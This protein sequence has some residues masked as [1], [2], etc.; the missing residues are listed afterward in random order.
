LNNA[1]FAD[2][3]SLTSVEFP[4]ATVISSYAL[5]LN[6]GLRYVSLPAVEFIEEGAF[7]YGVS[8]SVVDFG[9]KLTS[10]PTLL[11]ANA[12]EGVPTTCAICVP[13][14]LYD[15]WTSAP[16][17]AK[18]YAAGYKFIRKGEKGYVRKHEVVDKTTLTQVLAPFKNLEYDD[19][20]DVDI[21]TVVSALVQLANLT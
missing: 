3:G 16:E 13:D 18:L 11:S 10:V 9:D 1:A 8:L 4:S 2:C 20:Y 7:S 12:F 21:D 17:W 14:A 15:A 6:E 19:G 5:N